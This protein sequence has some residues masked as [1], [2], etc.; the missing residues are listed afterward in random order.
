MGSLPA[1]FNPYISAVNATSSV[2]GKHLSA[3]D[4][5]LTIIE[6]Y[7]CRNLKNKSNKKNENVAFYFNDS[8]KGKKGGSSSKNDAVCHNC[9]KEGHYKSECWAEGGGKEGQG[10]KQ[11]GKAKAKGKGK[12]TA[13]TSD[14]KKEEQ[15]KDEEAW[16]ATTDVDFFLDETVSDDFDDLDTDFE[17]VEAYSCFIEGEEPVDHT[18]FR[19]GA[20]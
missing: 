9:G 15:P 19:Q 16:M 14:N 7:E 8:E 10:P 3:D 1:S 12:E 4:L 17:S 11:K 18:W 20:Q 13:A 2:L 5:M 6:E